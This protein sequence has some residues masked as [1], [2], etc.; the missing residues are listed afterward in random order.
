MKSRTKTIIKIILVIAVVGVALFEAWQIWM[1]N[2][3]GTCEGYE[4]VSEQKLVADNASFYNA[5]DI[6]SMTT[7]NGAKAFDKNG[8]RKWEVAFGLENPTIVS[9]KDVSAI[10]DVGGTVV[11]VISADGIPHKLDV[12]F[13]IVKAD[14]AQQ[15]VTAVLMNDG[16]MDIIQVYDIEGKLRVEIGT[17]TKDEGFPVDIALSDDGKKLVTAYVSFKG[18]ELISKATFYNADD[19]GK[20][21]IENIVGQRTFEGRLVCDVDF[22]GNDTV[23]ILLDDGFVLYDMKE[24]PEFVIDKKFEHEIVDLCMFDTGVCAVTKNS[25]EK[26]LHFFNT[27][28]KEEKTV[29]NLPAYEKIRASNDEA[30]LYSPQS[31]RIYRKNGTLKFS[32]MLD[33]TLEDVYFGGKDRYFFVDSGSVKAIKIVSKVKEEK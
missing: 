26:T 4:I 9:C 30:I 19:V 23:G 16:D 15:G 25:N 5:H 17:K 3:F 24:I 21:F 8:D 29:E 28:G 10:A 12:N 2:Y 22:L 33:G 20:N 31:V 6:L 18:D 13:P 14:V 27:D 1:R 32:C 7:I 11:Y